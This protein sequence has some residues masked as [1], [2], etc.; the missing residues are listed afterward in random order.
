MGI[1]M[2]EVKFE[3]FVSEF[4]GTFFLVLTVGLN[5]I[6]GTPLAAVSFGAILMAMIFSTGAVS[7]GHFNPAV[8]IGVFLSGFGRQEL[9]K[10]DVCG[11][12]LTQC[13]AGILGGITS[14]SIAAGTFALRPAVGYGYLDAL[15]VEVFFTA[16]L[17]FVMLSV[18]T[19][20][21][22]SGN[23]FFG[24]AVGFTVMASSF[25]VG[26]VS[27]CSLNPAL[28]IG[29]SASNW[30]HAGGGYPLF[31]IYFCGPVLGACIAAGLFRIVRRLE[32][33]LPPHMA[34]VPDVQA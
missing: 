21:M 2:K 26:G 5:A 9:R 3:A 16:A 7:G 10:V 32:F 1:P 14:A 25:A 11:Y 27:G 28:A 20:R 12:I 24:L 19:T 22:E 17:V 13:C 15:V 30:L 33:Q 4:I 18:Q 29:V 34:T 6:Q 23:E 31:S 8:T